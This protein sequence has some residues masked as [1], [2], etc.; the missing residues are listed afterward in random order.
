MCV[1]RI[2]NE[3]KYSTFIN[4]C[5]RYCSSKRFD[6]NSRKVFFQ[7]L[8]KFKICIQ[9][10]QFV[11][12]IQCSLQLWFGLLL[13]EFLAVKIAELTEINLFYRFLAKVSGK[14]NTEFILTVKLSIRLCFLCV[15][16]T[17]VIIF[18]IGLSIISCLNTLYGS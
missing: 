3:K 1:N 10:I 11:I 16:S 8:Q 5:I 7:N 15:R 12:I 9:L 6:L 14:K 2:V 13:T 17:F 18:F 4:F